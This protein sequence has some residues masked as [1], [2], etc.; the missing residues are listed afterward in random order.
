[1]FSDSCFNAPFTEDE[2][3]VSAN[4]PEIDGPKPGGGGLA[5]GVRDLPP[6]DCEGV[7]NVTITFEVP[8]DQAINIELV[9]TLPEGLVGQDPSQGE[10]NDDGSQL[11]F[12]GEVSNGD[13]ISYIIPGAQAG[14]RYCLGSVDGNPIS[15]DNTLFRPLLRRCPEICDNGIDDDRDRAIDCDDTD[16]AD[17]P[18]CT[19]IGQPEIC[20]NGLDDDL[21]GAID[22]VDIDCLE[23]ASCLPE[24]ICDNGTDDDRDGAVDCD[25]TD[26]ADAAAC[27]VVKGPTFVRG[28]ANSDGSINLTDGVV[29]LLYLFS[30]GA[31]PACLDS[32]DTNDTGGIEIT[33]AIIV[34]GWLFT[35]GAAPA[36]P[37]PLSPG[38]SR[39]ECGVDDTDDGIGCDRPS[40]V[41]P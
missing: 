38:Y 18:A 15:G 34:F 3:S 8:G 14:A 27:Q 19:G 30:G 35:G 26:C 20:N 9:E 12:Q 37:S 10:F 41:C 2:V 29:P 16:C 33:D 1:M 40:P 5:R 39:E 36:A 28:D 17:A 21:D 7:A 6:I 24:E 23:D 4:N 31:A 25:D 11:V 13:S 32:A 22:C